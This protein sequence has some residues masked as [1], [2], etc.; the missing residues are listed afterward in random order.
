MA[1]AKAKDATLEFLNQFKDE[2]LWDEV[3]DGIPIFIPHTAKDEAGNVKYEVSEERLHAI[4]EQINQTFAQYGKPI[5]W[6]V[7]HTKLVTK[8]G[9]LTF[10]DQ[11]NQPEIVAYGVQAKVAPFGPKGIPS[12]QVKRYVRKGKLSQVNEYPERSPEFDPKTNAMPVVALLKGEPR[13]PMGMVQCASEEIGVFYASG[14]FGETIHDKP[15]IE[16]GPTEQPDANDLT[17][18]ERATADRY[19]RYY[20]KALPWLGKMKENYAMECGSPTNGSVMGLGG[21][22]SPLGGDDDTADLKKKKPEGVEHMSATVTLEQYQALQ[23]DLLAIKEQYAASESVRIVAE[24]DNLVVLK[25]KAK[26]TERLKKLDDKGRAELKAEILENYQEKPKDP[27]GD[28]WGFE[29]AR[30]VVPDK[31]LP[32]FN[33]TRHTPKIERYAREHNLDIA[34]YQDYEAAK[35]AVLEAE[36][37]AKV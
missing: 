3:R 6:Q 12:I 1:K 24:L 4:V 11:A 13:L 33:A 8:E 27:T 14:M 22:K 7:G 29:P 20:E 25:D 19:M 9:K 18:E 37:K 17:V 10:D 32:E 30:D 28:D 2:S 31:K 21:G 15:N 16:P 36:I 5:K 26:L 34:D 23:A 35:T